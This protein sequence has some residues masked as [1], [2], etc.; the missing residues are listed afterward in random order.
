MPEGQRDQ[1]APPVTSNNTPL[2]TG[3]YSHPWFKEGEVVKGEWSWVEE[4][5][6]PKDIRVT[7]HDGAT[8]TGHEGP[9]VEIEWIDDEKE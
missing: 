5:D 4:R 8:W 3:D 7:V 2:P 1:D 9:G 6:G